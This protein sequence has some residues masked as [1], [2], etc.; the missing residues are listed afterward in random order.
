[1]NFQIV[2]GTSLSIPGEFTLKAYEKAQVTVAAGAA[3]TVNLPSGIQFLI[4][5]SSV[6]GNALTYTVNSETTARLLNAAHVFLGTGAVSILNPTLT[7]MVF[8][9]GL[10]ADVILDILIGI[11]AA[12]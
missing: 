5:T 4:I 11:E 8:T 10:T 2:H 9:N 12:T 6:Y 1:M 3:S 7:K